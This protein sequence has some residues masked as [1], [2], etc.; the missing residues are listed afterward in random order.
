MC[1][2]K[3]TSNYSATTLWVLN[4]CK[5]LDLY[6]MP[7]LRLSARTTTKA[8]NSARRRL[9][10]LEKRMGASERLVREMRSMVEGEVA[11]TNTTGSAS[12]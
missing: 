4:Q 11:S 2:Y 8:M 3:R 1:Q 6:R 10:K 9:T 5:V 12:Y 7:P